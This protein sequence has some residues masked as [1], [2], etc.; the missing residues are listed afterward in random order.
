MF[1]CKGVSYHYAPKVMAINRIDL[2][3]NHRENTAIL[4]ANGCGKS[5]LIK[6]LCGL[7]FPTEG[8]LEA[9][10][11]PLSEAVLRDPIKA[12][13]FRRKIG[14]VFQNADAQ[15]FSPTVRDEL[16]FAPLQMGLPREE[17]E[18]RAEDVAGL[19]RITHLLERP[20]FQLSGGEKRKACLGCVLT[21]NPEVLLLD[22]PTTGLDPRSQEELVALLQQLS[23]AG[24]TLIAA[25]H[26]LSLAAR[27]S[28][29]CVVMS[30]NHEIAAH[31]ETNCMLADVRLLREANLIA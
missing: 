21:M 26:D 4:G 15:L 25:T 3:L 1:H 8:T 30:E 17:A 14:F 9:F 20:P 11:E 27:I 19:L 7:L 6:L 31:G 5:T 29:R 10:S 16:A 2:T 22:E 12:A 13:Q 18:Q 23:H 24:K 28:T